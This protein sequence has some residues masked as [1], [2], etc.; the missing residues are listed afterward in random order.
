M[1]ARGRGAAFARTGFL[2]RV[3]IGKKIAL[4]E[5]FRTRHQRLRT[6]PVGLRKGYLR[7]S[8][9]FWTKGCIES[10]GPRRIPPALFSAPH[11][12]EE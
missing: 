5:R 11:L 9:E 10:S 1:S 8:I 7:H 3:P 6:V 12:V 2:R 4:Y